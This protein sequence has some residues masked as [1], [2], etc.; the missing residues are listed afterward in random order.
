ML[1]WLG[2]YAIVAVAVA[3]PFLLLY[4]AVAAFW[5]CFTVIGSAIRSL[6][7][8]RPVRPVAASRIE[9]WHSRAGG[10]C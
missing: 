1:Y 7:T 2:A 8:A 4:L 9:L 3:L 6:R 5:W 10:G